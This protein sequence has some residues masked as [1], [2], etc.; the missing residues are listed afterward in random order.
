MEVP[1]AQPLTSENL[2]TIKEGD[3]SD[4]FLKMSEQ[5]VCKPMLP[6]QGIS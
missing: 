2:I 4:K 5:G 6:Q 3:R 1:L